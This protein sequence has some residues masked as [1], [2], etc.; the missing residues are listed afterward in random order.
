MVLG[1][2]LSYELWKDQTVSFNT[3]S[4]EMHFKSSKKF[5]NINIKDKKILSKSQTFE[6]P[7]SFNRST[8]VLRPILLPKLC[9]SRSPAF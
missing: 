6:I 9:L 7:K 1:Q 4:K 3:L 8:I 5:K 2:S